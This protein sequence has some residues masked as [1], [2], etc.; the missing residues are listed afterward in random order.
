M[1]SN[2]DKSHYKIG[3]I[4]DVCEYYNEGIPRCTYIGL[5]T[6]LKLYKSGSMYSDSKQFIIYEI[7]DL[8]H[9]IIKTAEE[10][11]IMKVMEQ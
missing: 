1:D 8:D 10:F 11:A 2:E 4:V 3:D 9:N 7:L 5:I 6:N